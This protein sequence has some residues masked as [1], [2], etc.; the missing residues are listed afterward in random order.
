MPPSS[1]AE[2]RSSPAPVLPAA[3][4]RWR[5]SA[6]RWA[7]GFPSWTGSP[8]PAPSTAATCARRATTSSSGSR[9]APTQRGPLSW[10]RGSSERGFGSSVIDI[11]EMPGH[12]APQDRDLLAGRATAARVAR[13]RRTRGV[14][15]VG[16]GG[17]AEGRGVRGQLHQ[18]ER[19]G[20]DRKR[21][22]RR[23]R[24]GCAIWATRSWRST[25]RSTGKWMG[26]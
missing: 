12:A 2:A 11:R 17:G 16:G 19:H 22:S 3:R 10:R 13:G 6:R 21:V 26:G 1:P 4:E 14:S 25:C 15:R 5:R 20:A 23:P 8:R 18:G 24:L 9:S 7:G